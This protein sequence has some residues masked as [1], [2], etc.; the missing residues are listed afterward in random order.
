MY[1]LIIN[2][3]ATFRTLGHLIKAATVKKLPMIPTV[4]IRMV[5]MAAKVN[6]LADE[7]WI[8]LTNKQTNSFELEIN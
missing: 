4:M 2:A 7:D 1:Y 8:K 3:A 5:M 6:I